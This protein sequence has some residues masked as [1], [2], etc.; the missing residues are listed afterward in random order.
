MSL[1]TPAVFDTGA[2][3]K[4]PVKKRVIIILGKSFDAAVAKEK[5]A[6]MK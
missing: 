5:H 3:A 6:P 2:E 4:K 1:R